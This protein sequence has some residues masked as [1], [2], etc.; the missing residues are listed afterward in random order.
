MLRF[1]RCVTFSF[2]LFDRC[3]RLI[4]PSNPLL[5]TSNPEWD[6]QMG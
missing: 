5:T 1:E 4:N 3:A 6:I 2:T